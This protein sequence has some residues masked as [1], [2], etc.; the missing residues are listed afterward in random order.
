LSHRPYSIG[1]PEQESEEEAN[2]H[3]ALLDVTPNQHHAKLHQHDGLDGS[4]F[5]SYISL[6]DKPTTVTNHNN[7][8]H[9]TTG[10]PGSSAPGDTAQQGSSESVSRLDHRHSRENAKTIQVNL[11][12]VATWRGKFII[13]DSAISAGSMVLVWQAPGPYTGKG[14]R[15]D[16]AELQ[17]VQVIAVEPAD[18][19]AIVMWQT[20]PIIAAVTSMIYG[21]L[22]LPIVSKDAPGW[23]R[24]HLKRRHKVRGNVKFTYLVF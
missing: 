17:P 13:V 16:E 18:G 20:P 23:Y 19:S 22:A 12:A 1:I 21:G 2:S 7:V 6:T 8:S 9:V 14:L 3:E 15:A 5:I 24:L 10:V 11:S 4:G